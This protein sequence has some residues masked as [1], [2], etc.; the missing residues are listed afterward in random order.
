[1]L[2]LFD[3]DSAIADTFRLIEKQLACGCWSWDLR[4]NKMEWSRG[5]FELLGLEPGSVTPSFNAIVQLTHPDDRPPQADVERMIR[6]ALSIRRRF[7]IIRPGGSIVWILCQITVLVNAEGASVRAIGVCSDI[8]MHQRSISPLREAEE[9]YRA[10]VRATGALVW[11][12]AGDCSIK[13]SPNWGEHRSEPVE[14]TLGGGWQE[15]IHPDD[16]PRAVAAFNEAAKAKLDCTVEVRVQQEDGLHVWKRIHAVPILD[17]AKKIKEWLGVNS[18]IQ[19]QKYALTPGR[20]RRLTGAQ[21]RAARGL[22]RWSTEDLAAAAQTSRATIRR[23]EET[24]GLLADQEPS[25][26]AI[27][28]ALSE[29]GVEFLFPEIGK[30]GVRPR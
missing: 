22:L 11:I 25:L 17:D 12:A 9:R 5:Y 8:T 15:L 27:E 18:D 28:G 26:Q 24:D 29:Q 1:M 6:E 4:T 7:R 16:R 10:L 19:V 2:V 13:E 30:P 23:L 21:I 14:N 20:K 3:G